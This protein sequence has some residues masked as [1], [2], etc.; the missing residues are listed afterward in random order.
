[1]IR[2]LIRQPGDVP[3]VIVSCAAISM[4]TTWQAIV[5]CQ[6][7]MAAHPIARHDIGESTNGKSYSH[8]DAIGKGCQERPPKFSEIRDR[9]QQQWY[10]AVILRKTCRRRA[11]HVDPNSNLDDKSIKDQPFKATAVKGSVIWTSSKHRTAASRGASAH[12]PSG[13]GPWPRMRLCAALLMTT[14]LERASLSALSGALICR[15]C[16]RTAS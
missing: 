4:H 16:R 15:W 3:L 14:A 11:D 5:S 8:L 7:I 9:T 12:P 6:T 13:C 2:V 10:V 1:M